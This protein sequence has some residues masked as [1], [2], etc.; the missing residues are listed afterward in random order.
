VNE[1]L[2][3]Y[4]TTQEND[5]TEGERFETV[6]YRSTQL[7]LFSRPRGEAGSGSDLDSHREL[8]LTKYPIARSVRFLNLMTKTRVCVLCG[9]NNCG[10]VCC[11]VIQLTID[12]NSQKH[13]LLYTKM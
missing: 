6:L 12:P 4:R 2:G 3:G 1:E 10:Y 8:V 5:Q 7:L 13:S 11:Y 9:Y